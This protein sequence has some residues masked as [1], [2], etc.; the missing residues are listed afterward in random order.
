MDYPKRLALRWAAVAVAVTAVLTYAGA[1]T[2]HLD[3]ASTTVSFGMFAVL[4]GGSAA[5]LAHEVARYRRCP[6]CGRQQEGK[7]GPC[8]TC[9]YDVAARPRFVCPEGH[10]AAFEPGLC[11]CGRRRQ[12]WQP[13]DV[14][15]HVRRSLWWGGAL[16]FALVATGLLVR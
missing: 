9:E 7:A 4:F 16:L 13:P 8:P 1:A 12:P 5:F 10:S 6:R 14:A 11:E 2:Q 3:L 15:G